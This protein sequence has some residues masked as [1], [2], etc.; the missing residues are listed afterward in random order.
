MCGE[1]T[2]DNRAFVLATC[3]TPG[4]GPAELAAYLAEGVFGHCGQPVASGELFLQTRE[5]RHLPSGVFAR[6]PA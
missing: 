4:I 2:A 1:L 6:W 3:H 5:G